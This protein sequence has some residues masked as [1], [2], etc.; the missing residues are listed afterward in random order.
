MY[1]II[2]SIIVLAD[3]LKTSKVIYLIFGTPIYWL[4]LFSSYIRHALITPEINLSTKI[5]AK[6]QILI[7]LRLGKVD[8]AMAS[9]GFETCQAIIQS[10]L[11]FFNQFMHFIVDYVIFHCC[12]NHDNE[13]MKDHF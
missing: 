13:M 8:L 11:I 9:F 7:D 6:E 10:I 4:S 2:L 12:R 1:L 5:D 3:I